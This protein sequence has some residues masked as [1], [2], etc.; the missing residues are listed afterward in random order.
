M[1]FDFFDFSKATTRSINKEPSINIAKSGRITFNKKLTE[2]KEITANKY[3]QIGFDK[4][5]GKIAI[6]VLDTNKN[7]KEEEDPRAIKVNFIEKTKTLYVTATPFFRSIGFDLENGVG[8]I[9]VE[10]DKDGLIIAQPPI[11]EKLYIEELDGKKEES[12][13]KEEIKKEE[14]KK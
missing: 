3:V 12:D 13:K 10:I 5:S 2:K 11:Q 1:D 4:K 8:S 14:V 7:E 9:Q 6:K